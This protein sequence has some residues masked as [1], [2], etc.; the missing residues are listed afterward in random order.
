[1]VL[2]TRQHPEQLKD[3]ICSPGGTSAYA[4]HQL[5]RAGFRG[6]L[7]EAVQAG[8][9]RSRQIGDKHDQFNANPVAS[10]T[11]GAVVGAGLDYD[12]Q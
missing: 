10:A 7:I 9:Q 12:C 1:M 8:T 11:G 3:D 4:L 6:A 2:E 5:E